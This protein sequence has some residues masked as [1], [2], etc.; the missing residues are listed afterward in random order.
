MK[1]AEFDFL[2]NEKRVKFVFITMPVVNILYIILVTY[3]SSQPWLSV[4]VGLLT[5]LFGGVSITIGKKLNRVHF[6]SVLALSLNCI[7]AGLFC[8]VSGP[9][10]PSFLVGMAFIAAC[11]ILLN[12]LSEVILFIVLVFI[13]VSIGSFIAGKNLADVIVSLT[14]LLIYAVVII[15]LLQFSLKQGV[16]IVKA[17]ALIEEKNKNI[18]DS[19]NYALRIQQAKLPE[20]Q[21]IYR[22][23]PQSFVLFKPKDIVSGDFYFFHQKDRSV[24]LAAAVRSPG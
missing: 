15:R 18:T 21:E 7:N 2:T 5:M 16:N 23:I 9:N 10:A 14:G 8:G 1:G 24:Y 22:A 13:S 4:G 3:Y 17:K 19:I 6:F 12:K 11:A 20:L